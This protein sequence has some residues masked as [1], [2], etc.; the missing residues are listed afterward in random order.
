M[1]TLLYCCFNNNIKNNIRYSA[2]QL[3]R[4]RGN[5]NTRVHDETGTAFSI[6]AARGTCEV[7]ACTRA[8]REDE[9]IAGRHRKAPSCILHKSTIYNWDKCSIS[10]YTVNI[11]VNAHSYQKSAVYPNNTYYIYYYCA[12]ILHITLYIIYR[13]QYTMTHVTM[14]TN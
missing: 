4:W 12:A 3:R 1:S 13:V 14:V 11:T 10:N 7:T 8:G 9:W 6:D 2:A 5:L